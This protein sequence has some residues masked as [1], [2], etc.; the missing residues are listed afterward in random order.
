ME[1]FLGQDKIEEQLQQA[2]HL[3]HY[4][5]SI[6]V[7][8]GQRSETKSIWLSDLVH[9]CTDGQLHLC[10]IELT[11]LTDDLQMLSMIA[12]GFGLP[13]QN[14]DIRTLF[15]L[16]R[17]FQLDQQHRGKSVVLIRNA[18]LLDTSTLVYLRTL[19]ELQGG[20]ESFQFVLVDDEGHLLAKTGWAGLS[21]L[22][23]IEIE[24][25]GVKPEAQ[26]P[27]PQSFEAHLDEAS[28]RI[29]ESKPR[30]ARFSVLFAEAM[31]QKTVFGFPRAHL[32]LLSI[33]A[34]A[35]LFL[36]MV[37]GKSEVPATEPMVSVTLEVPKMYSG[38]G[39]QR[40]E[41][42]QPKPIKKVEQKGPVQKDDMQITMPANASVEEKAVDAITELATSSQTI[43]NTTL[44]NANQISKMNIE[45]AV[46]VAEP[47]TTAPQ[48]ST[49][50][51]KP[52]NTKPEFV[53]LEKFERLLLELD[54]Q[55]YTLQLYGTYE[56]DKA[57][58]FIKNNPDLP[59]VRYYRGEYRNKPWYMVV[60]GVYSD[61]TAA[62]KAVKNLPS[63][64]QRQKPWVRK[65]EGIQTV[66]RSNSS[67]R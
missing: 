4:G 6:L 11:D 38:P 64:L 22:F 52:E 28:S 44:T 15:G 41:N 2:L 13:Y 50:K 54:S 3:I 58:T 12:L 19:S 7:V 37:S 30:L 18:H 8:G 32:T 20:Y 47:Q 10:T 17:D 1:D 57:G 48:D 21:D 23:E 63:K 45:P 5:H 35:I 66:I 62:S 16:L 26:P 55:S 40:A 56:I 9:R 33:V 14:A 46:S 49:M 29:Q 36:L 34:V 27:S 53:Q 67:V 39:E 61:A 65:L 60:S 25:D 31:K 59:D 51:I 24:A 42:G 43:E